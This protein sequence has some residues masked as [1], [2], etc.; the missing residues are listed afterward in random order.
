MTRDEFL[1]EIRRETGFMLPRDRNLIISHFIE[2]LRTVSDEDVTSVLGTP[3]GA[4]NG[5]MSDS[6]NNISPQSR[7]L[8]I[9]AAFAAA[10]VVINITL[11]IAGI[12]I[13]LS[14]VFAVIIAGL[15][16]AAAAMWLGGIWNFVYTILSGSDLSNV[17]VGCGAGLV[18]SGFGIFL[19]LAVIKLYGRFIP[20]LLRS[21]YGAAVRVVSWFKTMV[22]RLI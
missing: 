9:A 8:M 16:F 14:A 11:V 12:V 3:K 4:I 22:W 2:R 6:A 18:T 17:L 13:A 20:W 1:A 7:I 19:L 10:P 5:F 15:P 21:I